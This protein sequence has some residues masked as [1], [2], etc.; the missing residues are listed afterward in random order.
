ML[1]LYEESSMLIMKDVP[2]TILPSSIAF[3]LIKERM[4]LELL[5]EDIPSLERV[6]LRE[7]LIYLTCPKISIY[8]MPSSCLSKAYFTLNLPG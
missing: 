7:V 1:N 8:A 3:L 5:Y 4:S 2:E 6:V